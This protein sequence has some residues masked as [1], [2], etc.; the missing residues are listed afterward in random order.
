MIVPTRPQNESLFT[1]EPLEDLVFASAPS[2][3]AKEVATEEPQVCGDELRDITNADWEVKLYK[4]VVFGPADPENPRNFSK[5]KIRF[6][7]SKPS[8]VGTWNTDQWRTSR[9]RIPSEPVWLAKR[10]NFAA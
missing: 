2:T 3:N 9:C 1:S 5:R 10:R 6:C 8:S 4:M 7:V